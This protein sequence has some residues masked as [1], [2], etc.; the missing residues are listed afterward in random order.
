MSNGLI[1]PTF[2]FLVLTV[3]FKGAVGVVVLA[4]WTSFLVES[5][6]AVVFVEAF[7]SASSEC[8]NKV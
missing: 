5:S 8:I 6:F 4:G 3:V 1:Q 2:S 7:L